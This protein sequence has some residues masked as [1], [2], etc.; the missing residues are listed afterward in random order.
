MVTPLFSHFKLVSKLLPSES[1][2]YLVGMFTKGN[3]AVICGDGMSV[4]KDIDIGSMFWAISVPPP[5]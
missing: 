4:F 1:L 3:A 2:T 5:S